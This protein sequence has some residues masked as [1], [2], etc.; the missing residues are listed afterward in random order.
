MKFLYGVSAVFI[1]VTANGCNKVRQSEF[2]RLYRVSQAAPIFLSDSERGK[3]NLWISEFR[4]EI[5]AANAKAD[6]DSEKSM[7]ELYTMAESLFETA[8]SKADAERWELLKQD[9]EFRKKSEIVFNSF[10]GVF[11]SELKN[12]KGKATR[13]QLSKLTREEAQEDYSTVDKI[14]EKGRKMRSLADSIYEKY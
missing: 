8:M 6:S 1:L 5:K 11:E 12:P 13:E 14:W 9:D 7:V 10:K 4:T 3:T 2:E